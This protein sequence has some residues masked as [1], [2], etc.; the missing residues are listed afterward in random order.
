[1][2]RA[3]FDALLE[4]ER[5]RQV[6][7]YAEPLALTELLAHLADQSDKD[8]RF[9]RAAVVRM[10]QRCA[11]DGPCRIIRDSES[12]LV[13]A[14]RGKGLAKN[15]EHTNQLRFLLMHVGHDYPL[16]AIDSQL[17]T[18][19]AH[20]AAMEAQ[21]AD[22]M[23]K[24]QN[25]VD[26]GPTQK[27][28]PIRMRVRE[29]TR[30]ASVRMLVGVARQAASDVAIARVRR[31]AAAWVEFGARIYD[32]VVFDRVN[33]ELPEARNFLWDQWLAFNIGQTIGVTP[34]WLVTDDG[35]FADAAAATG[36]G[37]RVFRRPHAGPRCE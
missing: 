17:R 37:D 12:R 9:C 19:A 30:E 7:R 34:L 2:G 29:S 4:L 15:D 8:F 14:M 16:S 27:N 28:D 35:A 3:R 33:V 6:M 24:L 36:Y 10:F 31:G 18:I 13:E 25:S 20:V 5:Q 32:R 1:M 21:W 26:P 11:G 23:R 22:T